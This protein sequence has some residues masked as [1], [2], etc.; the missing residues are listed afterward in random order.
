MCIIKLGEIYFIKKIGGVRYKT[1]T[2]SAIHTKNMILLEK[3]S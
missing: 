1:I 3:Y 2:L